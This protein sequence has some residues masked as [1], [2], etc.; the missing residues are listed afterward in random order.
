MAQADILIREGE[1]VI[2]ILVVD[3]DREIRE[4]LEKLFADKGYGS[5][6]AA[7]GKEALSHDLLLAVFRSLSLV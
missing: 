7:T 5:M 4:S 1:A 6:T 3:G 2:N